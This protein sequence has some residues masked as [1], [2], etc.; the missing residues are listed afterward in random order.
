VIGGLITVRQQRQQTGDQLAGVP[1]QERAERALPRLYLGPRGIEQVIAQPI[2]PRAEQP[3]SILTVGEVSQLAR[4]A[5][6][7]I[8]AVVEPG[9]GAHPLEIVAHARGAGEEIAHQ[10]PAGARRD[11]LALA[12]TVVRDRR[13]AT[14]PVHPQPRPAR[15]E[16]ATAQHRGHVR[17]ERR[18]RRRPV[19]ELIPVGRDHERVVWM[20]VEREQQ[21]THG[22]EYT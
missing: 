12:L 21:E 2:H 22:P 4:I 16:I 19:I 10:P 11:G 18:R 8:E 14:T 17:P 7:Q 20:R 9:V 3:D 5:D 1:P 15:L 13:Q 6:N